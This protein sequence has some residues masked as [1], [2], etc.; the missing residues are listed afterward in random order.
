[1]K[2]ET[3]KIDRNFLLYTF[4]VK[5][6]N[7]IDHSDQHIFGPWSANVESSEDFGKKSS[8]THVAVNYSKN[9]SRN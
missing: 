3:G 7:S 6:D 2:M 9:R 4:D 1:M 5:Q 8:Q